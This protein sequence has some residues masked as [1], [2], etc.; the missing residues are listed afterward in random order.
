MGREHAPPLH[1]ATTEDSAEACSKKLSRGLKLRLAPG[2]RRSERGESHPTPTNNR[3]MAGEATR[4]GGAGTV[5]CPPLPIR[6]QG[7]ER[8]SLRRRAEPRPRTAARTG[9]VAPPPDQHQAN[10]KD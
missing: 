3:P 7:G 10:A 5:R 4:I 1:D 8:R 9:A 6:D 2:R